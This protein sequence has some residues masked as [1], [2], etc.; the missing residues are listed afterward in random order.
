MTDLNRYMTTGLLFLCEPIIEAGVIQ[1]TKS[2]FYICAIVTTSQEVEPFAV[3]LHKKGI[4]RTT[5]RT[6]DDPGAGYFDSKTDAENALAR[7]ARS[8]FTK[9]P[10]YASH[11]RD[12]Y[13]VCRLVAEYGKTRVA[14]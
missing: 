11:Q 2:K 7:Q 10:C 5:T 6:D 1:E 3:Y 4:W 12:I 9:H 13:E 8:G 14:A